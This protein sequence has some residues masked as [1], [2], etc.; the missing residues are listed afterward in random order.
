MAAGLLTPEAS[1]ESEALSR[2]L[3]PPGIPENSRSTD[4]PP[5]L[6]P[7]LVPELAHRPALGRGL[8]AA[9]P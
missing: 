4:L 6:V 1:H 2:R 3:V 5:E 7:E 9:F 8:L